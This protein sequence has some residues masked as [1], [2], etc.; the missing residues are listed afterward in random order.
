[1]TELLG[2]TIV[3]ET[4]E[5]SVERNSAGHW[6]NLH[7]TNTTTATF[8]RRSNPRSAAITRMRHIGL[9]RLLMAFPAFISDPGRETDSLAILGGEV[10]MSFLRLSAEVFR[11]F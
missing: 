9:L 5:H 6:R 7:P 3:K 11:I 1:M 10:D 2:F 4:S 8:G